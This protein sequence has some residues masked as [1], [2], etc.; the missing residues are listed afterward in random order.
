MRYNP[1]KVNLTRRNLQ[2]RLRN[3]GFLLLDEK[4]DQK[5]CM[6]WRKTKEELSTGAE[7]PGIGAEWICLL[8]PP[9]LQSAVILGGRDR[10]V[11]L[12]G[13]LAPNESAHNKVLEALNF[14]SSLI[15]W[16]LSNH[17]CKRSNNYNGWVTGCFPLSV[18]LFVSGCFSQKIAVGLR[19]PTKITEEACWTN[20]SSQIDNGDTFLWSFSLIK[21]LFVCIIWVFESLQPISN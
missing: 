12:E 5:Q 17:S 10:V 6:L 1:L 19:F 11:E 15:F 14:R 21:N 18:L 2:Q 20:F 13:I 3:C 9:Q 7:A 8:W 16:S 4:H